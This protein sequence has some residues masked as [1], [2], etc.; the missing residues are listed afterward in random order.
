NKVNTDLDIIGMED[1]IKKVE[2]GFKDIIENKFK[3]KI[4]CFKGEQGNG[5]STTLREIKR[6]ICSKYISN[7]REKS[8]LIID[9]LS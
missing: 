9:N 2:S 4:V 8:Y 3:Y 7:K 5:K 1:E 6:K